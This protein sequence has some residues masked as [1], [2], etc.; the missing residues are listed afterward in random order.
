MHLSAQLGILDVLVDDA[1]GDD[2]PQRLVLCRHKLRLKRTVEHILVHHILGN[3][4]ATVSDV[5]VAAAL[6]RVEIEEL[7]RAVALVVLNVKV[8]ITHKVQVLEQLAH[9]AHELVV[10]LGNN[11]GMVAD[12]VGLMLLEQH[13]AQTHHAD[14]AVAVGIAGEH[15]HVL[16]VAGHAVLQDQI[17][18]V[19]AGIRIANDLFQLGAV[20]NLI[21]LFLA[22]ELV[23]PPHDAVR[24]LQNHRVRKI[25]LVEHFGR[26]LAL[27]V[28][29]RHGEGKGMRIGHTMLLA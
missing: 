22:L 8:G 3:V 17:V 29:H 15:A 4:K 25:D 20:G 14:L 18:G 6:A 7:K 12:A 26:C 2:H 5:V 11:T 27:G 24:R 9:A 28:Q 23:L 16:V 10:G 19:A 21:G 13:M 1:H